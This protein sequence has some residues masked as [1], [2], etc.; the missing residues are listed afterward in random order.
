EPACQ[1]H[2]DDPTV[3]PNGYRSRYRRGTAPATDIEYHRSWLEPEPFDGSLSISLPKGQWTV[4]EMVCG[5]IVGSRCLEL[6]WF[7]G[8]YHRLM[9]RRARQISV[10][11]SQIVRK[12]QCPLVAQNG[13]G[14]KSDSNPLCAQQRTSHASEI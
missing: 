2:R 10:A 3:R 9:L 12:V 8:L 1:V 5:S 6:C 14:V 7:H 11:L 13:H 4:V